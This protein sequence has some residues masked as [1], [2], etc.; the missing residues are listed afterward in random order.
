MPCVVPASGWAGIR[1]VD[2]WAEPGRSRI[3][4]GPPR[5]FAMRKHEPTRHI[6]RKCASFR[7]VPLPLALPSCPLG[8][9]RS[10][11][12]PACLSGVSPLA[13]AAS[14]PLSCWFRVSSVGSSACLRRTLSRPV[15][16]NVLADLTHSF[17]LPRSFCFPASIDYRPPTTPAA[18]RAFLACANPTTRQ[19]LLFQPVSPLATTF[20]N[21]S[22]LTQSPAIAHARA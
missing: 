8:P 18:T 21:N 11:C 16:S 3:I 14:S 12:L 2:G 10:S 5:V 7:Y 13:A 17:F 4:T 20:L 15:S 1:D 6:L 22:H 9:G 19:R